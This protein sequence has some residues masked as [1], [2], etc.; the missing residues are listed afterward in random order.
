MGPVFWG[1]CMR[2]IAAGGQ[3]VTILARGQRFQDIE[4]YGIVLEH[5]LNHPKETVP[6][7]FVEPLASSPCQQ[8][9]SGHGRFCGFGSHCD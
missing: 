7:Q 2:P 8:E 3:D 4:K 5:A 6:V 1:A 9:A